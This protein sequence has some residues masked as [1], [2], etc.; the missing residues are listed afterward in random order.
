MCAVIPAHILAEKLGFDNQVNAQ[1]EAVRCLGCEDAPC[2]IQCP[3]GV[4]VPKVNQAIVSGNNRR[5]AELVRTANPAAH[6][7][8]ACCP[9]EQFCQS[10]C[11]RTAI[12]APIDIRGLH[13][14]ATD[15]EWNSGDRQPQLPKPSDLEVAIVGS[16]PSSVACAIGLGQRGV[17]THIFEKE[18]ETGGLPAWA[19]P[20]D[21]LPAE[22][23]QRD[24]HNLVSYPVKIK[25]R[26]EITSLKE[27]REKYD[28]IYVGVGALQEG[29]LD[30][31]GLDGPDVYNGLEFLRVAKQTPDKI[32]MRGPVRII[33]GGN[34]AVDCALVAS[35]LGANRISVIY[36]R[37][38]A[39]LPAWDREV[40]EAFNRGVDFLFQ[41]QPL[42]IERQGE[43]IYRLICR[44]TTL[45]SP[46]DDG[47]RVPIPLTSE[48]ISLEAGM[49]II[50]AGQRT[51]I[52]ENDLLDR[53]ERGN[54]IID[55]ANRTN[56]DG[57]YAGGDATGK[58]GTV[59]QAVQSGLNAALWIAKDLENR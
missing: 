46:G 18:R 35:T 57:C 17:N 29:S 50:A 7:C 3:V 31:T 16:G 37:S 25:A 26:Q 21:R 45:G 1:R 34:V 5:A 47:R 42:A 33:G 27:L 6:V 48:S 14:F 58:C 41:L 24:M 54:I 12:D 10:V 28:A 13:R 53:D 52:F 8:G 32:V 49:V 36:R 23:V 38:R 19:I 11:V 9:Q 40:N 20:D 4:P 56:L 39:E 30:I 2:M 59:V 43:L 15:W 22:I 55:N 44:R 51:A